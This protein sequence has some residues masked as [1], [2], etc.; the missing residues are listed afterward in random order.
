MHKGNWTMVL[1]NFPPIL[2]EVALFLS[3][4]KVV[5]WVNFCLRYIFMIFFSALTPR[6]LSSACRYHMSFTL[7]RRMTSISPRCL[8]GS[9]RW[10]V[11]AC[12]DQPPRHAMSIEPQCEWRGG[13]DG[14]GRMREGWAADTAESKVIINL[15][16]NLICMMNYYHKPS[17]GGGEAGAQ[18]WRSRPCSRYYDCH[19]ASL[20]HHCCCQ[21]QRLFAV[22]WSHGNS[23]STLDVLAQFSMASQAAMIA[24]LFC[25]CGYLPL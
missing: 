13:V 12:I 6:L 14:R 8:H 21:Q 9:C 16:S 11:V 22:G 5:F 3:H 1:F 10:G 15:T 24:M 2:D 17:R 19:L 25:G 7:Q 4:C 18:R 23:T 20:P